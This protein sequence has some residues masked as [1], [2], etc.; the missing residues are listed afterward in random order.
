MMRDGIPREMKNIKKQQGEFT[1]CSI[2]VSE[3][4]EHKGVNMIMGLGG[5]GGCRTAGAVYVNELFLLYLQWSSSI[6]SNL[7]RILMQST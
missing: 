2:R 1:S 3:H 5:E 6:A 4:F 7:S